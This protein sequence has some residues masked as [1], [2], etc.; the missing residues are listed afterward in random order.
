MSHTAAIINIPHTKS[1]SDGVVGKS[2]QTLG[3]GG[4]FPPAG[5]F[6]FHPQM[7]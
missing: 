2:S 3:C 5:D 7:I 4:S 1:P 6:H